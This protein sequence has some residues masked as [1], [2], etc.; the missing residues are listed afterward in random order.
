MCVSA[1]SVLALGEANAAPDA[2]QLLE[3]A[4]LALGQSVGGV[5]LQLV[6]AG[7]LGV[8]LALGGVLGGALGLGVGADGLVHSKVQLL[9]VVSRHTSLDVLAEGLLVLLV[10]LLLHLLHPLLDVVSEDTGTVGLSVKL[11]R[12]C[13][14][15]RE[16]LVAVGNVQSSVDGSLQCREDLVSDGGVDKT[17]VEHGLEGTAVLVLLQLEG[18]TGHLLD[19]LCSICG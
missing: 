7:L 16:T 13:V 3:G 8:L 11:T 9:K 14:V 5:G 4:V 17:N 2:V 6:A 1:H 10:V 15:S 12:R 18:L 19:S